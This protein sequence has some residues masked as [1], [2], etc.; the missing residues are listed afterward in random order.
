MDTTIML[1]LYREQI[2]S[3]I[4]FND[5]E[6]YAF[7]SFLKVKKL[8][9]NECFVEA[10]KVCK[11]LAFIIKGAVRF[12]NSIDGIEIT[13]YFC[14]ENSFVTSIKS[15]LTGEPCLYDIKALE[16]TFFVSISKENMQ[17]M[18]LHPLLSCKVER[19]GRLVSEKFNIL[20]EDR[21]KSFIVKTPEERYLDLLETG[22]DIVKR[23][24]VQYIAQFIGI[25]PVSLSRIRKRI[26]ENTPSPNKTKF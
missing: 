1:T 6:W 12:C 22:K 11:E 7:A 17:A 24:P 25:T 8:G 4:T 9:K 3:L 19:F 10:G 13:G 2:K 16:E 18:L 26:L 14:F 20:F 23:I 15:Y 21:L 5:E